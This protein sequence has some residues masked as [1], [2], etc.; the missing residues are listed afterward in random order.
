MATIKIQHYQ[1]RQFGGAPPYGNHT[2]L[3]FELLANAAGAA[4]NSNSLAPIAN[5]DV[6]VLGDLPAGM[7]LQDLDVFILEGM[8]AT[9]TG[10]VGFR[11]KD[12]EDSTEVP[13][14]AAYFLGSTDLATAARVRAD[15]AKLVTLP[16]TAELIVTTGT[17]DNAKAAD[18]KLI[19]T[20]ELTGP[21]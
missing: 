8:T 4:V 18:I 20:G 2:S 19:V 12:G 9:V 14:D 10:T 11:Y 15:T 13:E 1:N 3:P 6:V 21:Q 16:K 5:G 7:R 17:A